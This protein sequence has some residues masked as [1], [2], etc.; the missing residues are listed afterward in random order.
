MSMKI[1]KECGTEVS[2]RAKIC[3]HCGKKLKSSAFRIFIGILILLMG[4]G[5]I[6]SS[7]ENNTSQTNA[8]TIEIQQQKITLEKFNRLENG[9]TYEQ[10]VNIIGEEG[11]LSTES[12]YGKESFKIYYWKAANGISNATI[13]FSNGKLTAKSQIGLD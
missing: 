12:S 9:M 2:R 10:V 8:N 11:T 5:I 7:G 1:C 3:P 4:I 6:A 13:S